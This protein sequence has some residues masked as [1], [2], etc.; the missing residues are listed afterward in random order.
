MRK[1]EQIHCPFAMRVVRLN[2]CQRTS[3]LRHALFAAMS[4][5]LESVPVFTAKLVALGLGEEELL[6][7]FTEFG[8][9][10]YANFAFACSKP[11]DAADD[12]LLV[13]E[14]VKPL[15]GDAPQMGRRFASAGCSWKRGRSSQQK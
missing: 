2:N 9:D 1:L 12:E 7:K 6:K 10:T 13:K 8:W 5:N 4:I 14:V 11:P 15:L 3:Q